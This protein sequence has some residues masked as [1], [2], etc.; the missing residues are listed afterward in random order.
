M[1]IIYIRHGKDEES[2]YKHDEKLSKEGKQEILEF[3]EKMVKKHGFPDI[4]YYSPFLRTQ[5][6]AKYII[7]KLNEMTDKKIF[8]KTDVKLGRFFTKDQRY[9]PSVRK[10]TYK[11]GVIMDE[12]YEEFKERV[13]S[14]LENILNNQKYKYKSIWNITHSLVLLHIAK[15]KNIERSKKVEYLDTLVIN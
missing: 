13:E 12:M 5:Q 7:K 2:R 10:S 1:S 4:I 6:T 9:N 15:I 8:Y 11:K 14:Q 3:T